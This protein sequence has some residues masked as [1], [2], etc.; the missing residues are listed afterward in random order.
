M[1]AELK[2]I[3]RQSGWICLA[4]CA[5]IVTL[6]LCFW[7]LSSLVMAS[8]GFV[9]GMALG[10][11]GLVMICSTVS[12]L[13]DQIKHETSRSRTGYLLRYIFYGIALIAGCLLGL[14]VI[15]MAAGLLVQ[16]ASLVLYALKEGK[17][18]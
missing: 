15:A 2:R 17:V 1:C 16:K 7:R 18:S 14:P 10:Y 5:L 9:W 8:L 12:N 13:S 4:L 3:L 11:V 6:V